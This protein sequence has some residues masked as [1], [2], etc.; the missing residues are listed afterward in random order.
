M[1]FFLSSVRQCPR[2]Q[3]RSAP[4]QNVL[5]S[6][7]LVCDRRSL[8]RS[9]RAGVPQGLSSARIQRQH[10]SVFI[11]G[12]CQSGIRCQHTRIIAASPGWMAPAN[13]PRFVIDRLNHAL[14][15]HAIVRAGPSIV[16]VG[17]L[18]K[19]KA[20]A[21]MSIDNKQSRLRIKTRRTKIG[22][23]AFIRRDQSSIRRRLLCRIWNWISVLVDSQ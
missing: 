13:F 8:H 10:V 7:Q 6:I 19:I 2:E 17:G 15:P 18:R 21:G 20:V 12:K 11:A 9:A 3:Y 14:A 5:P 4:D 1:R 23:A 22:Q 16:A